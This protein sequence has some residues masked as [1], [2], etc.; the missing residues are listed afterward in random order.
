MNGQRE[1]APQ[2]SWLW[3][4]L[5]IAV[6]AIFIYAGALK[7]WDPLHFFNDIQNYRILSYPLAI[8]LAFYLPWLEI[9]CG[10]ALIV[11]WM[12]SG[13][14]AILSALML[15]F[16]A[17]TVAAKARGINIDCGCFGSASKGLGFTS[18]ML[19]DFALLAALIALWFRPVRSND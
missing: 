13:A 11:G 16:I 17:A 6:G 10:V 14:V 4:A 8:R 19:I 2:R 5:S 15:I 3:P 7:A 9:L 12:R 1:E 18:H